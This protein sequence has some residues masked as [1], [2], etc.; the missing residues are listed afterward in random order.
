MWNGLGD[1]YLEGLFSVIFLVAPPLVGSPEPAPLRFFTLC[2]RLRLR[3]APLSPIADFIAYMNTSPHVIS[4]HE[5]WIPRSSRILPRHH[6]PKCSISLL[7]NE[8]HQARKQERRRKSA[9]IPSANPSRA[10]QRRT[11]SR[12]HPNRRSVETGD[13]RPPQP[14]ERLVSCSGFIRRMGCHRIRL[15]PCRLLRL[16]R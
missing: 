5:S 14:E 1:F 12:F 2:G 16:S 15:Y 11:S 3:L 4:H 9:D 8:I 13:C 7:Q 6:I 10:Y